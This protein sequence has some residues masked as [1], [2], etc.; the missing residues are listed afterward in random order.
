VVTAVTVPPAREGGGAEFL[1][2]DRPGQH[3]LRL[4]FL[5]LRHIAVT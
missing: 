5:S 2:V 3:P 4:P 1:I